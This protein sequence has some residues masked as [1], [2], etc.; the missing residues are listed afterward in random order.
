M[1][2]S[3]GITK[4]LLKLKKELEEKETERAELSGELNAI[5]RQLKNEYGL[6]SVEDAKD[7]IKEK[8]KE[9][10]IWEEVIKNGVEE[11]KKIMAGDDYG[12]DE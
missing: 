12:I 2:V 5:M 7:Y 11:I 10:E 8:E 1:S 4:E 9:I 3:A 6:P